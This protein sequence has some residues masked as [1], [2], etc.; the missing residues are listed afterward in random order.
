MRIAVLSDLHLTVAD[1]PVPDVA[2]DVVV[3]AGDI[4]RPQ[5]AIEWAKRFP[6]PVIY[7]A[8]NHEYY[9]GS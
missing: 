8:G 9:G 7:V 5:Q 3:L 6:V 4:A 2:C 1:M